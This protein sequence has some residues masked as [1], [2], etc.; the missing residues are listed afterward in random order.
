MAGGADLTPKD[1]EWGLARDAEVLSADFPLAVK[2]PVILAGI[3]SLVYY[4]VLMIMTEHRTRD[5]Y[6]TQLSLDQ[7]LA[8]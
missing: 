1:L 4:L 6:V 7:K 3:V 8:G 5:L 2:G